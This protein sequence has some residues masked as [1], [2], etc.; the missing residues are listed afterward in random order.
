MAQ[1]KVNSSGQALVETLLAIPLLFLLAVGAIQFTILFQARCAFDKACGE[2]ARQ[3]AANLLK[4]SSS[5]TTAIWNDLGSYQP[6]F[7]QQSL[8]ITTQTSQTTVADTVS[9]SLGSLG[10]PSIISKFKSYVINYSGQSWSVTI[11]CTPPSLVAVIFPSGIQF[12]SQ[13]SLIKY[14]S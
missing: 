6:Y 11:S 9:N 8:N 7:N 14:P 2:A 10:F 4:D 13:L 1:F 5:I 3:Y 12:Q